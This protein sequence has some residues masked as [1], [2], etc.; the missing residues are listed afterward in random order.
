MGFRQ[1]RVGA[2]VHVIYKCRIHDLGLGSLGLLESCGDRQRPCRPSS[3][4]SSGVRCDA[5]KRAAQP[6]NS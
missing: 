3:F 6:A 2:Y 5:Y 4:G 1:C